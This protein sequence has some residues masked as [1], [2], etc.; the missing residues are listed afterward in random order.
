MNSS[1]LATT[2]KRLTILFTL[3]VLVVV[4]VFWVSGISAKYLREQMVEKTEFEWV[5][6]SLL[7]RIT[8]GDRLIPN[9][10]GRPQERLQDVFRRFTENALPGNFVSYFILD[11][12]NKIVVDNIVERPV[13]ERLLLDAGNVF[14]IDTA[15]MVRVENL[16]NSLLWEKIIFYKGLEYS[17]EDFITDLISFFI[18][19]FFLAVILSFIG[20]RFVG[21]ALRPVAQN[22]QDMSDFIHNAGHELKTPLAVLRGNLQVMLAEKKYDPNL[23]QGSI[24]SVDV[25]N[26]LL[27][28]LRELSEIGK[29]W[30]KEKLSLTH[31]IK[32]ITSRFDTMI[33]EKNINFLLP[34]KDD[35]YVRANR[36]ELE[37]LLSNL[38]KNALKYTPEWGKIEISY[39]KNMLSISDSWIWIPKE[40]QEKIFE[41]FYQWSSIRSSE[42]Y[43]IGLSLVRKIVDANAW[44]IQVES[45]PGKG[46]IFKIIF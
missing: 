11:E 2:H 4:L 8:Q 10:Q 22:L 7:R 15:T 17:R 36:Y 19:S 33:Q 34:Q 27:E 40:E 5:T 1:K 42:G 3:M 24:Q 20:Y 12:E 32:N 44:K 26:W 30:G 46:S 39:K 28:S 35:F 25:T 13:F 18:L 31:T 45:E 14:Y 21:K 38:I 41:R 16:E 43:G 6:E 23:L 37:L 9:I 29:F